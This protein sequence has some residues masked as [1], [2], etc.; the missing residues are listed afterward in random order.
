MPGGTDPIPGFGS[1]A[2]DPGRAK[3]T[4]HNIDDNADNTDTYR[5]FVVPG[6]QI[7]GN[8]SDTSYGS[9]T[10]L[11]G[12]DGL[13]PF[14][15]EVSLQIDKVRVCVIGDTGSLESAFQVGIYAAD[16]DW[17]PTSLVWSTEVAV[18]PPQYFFDEL[19]V[20]FSLSPGRYLEAICIP[21]DLE[22]LLYPMLNWDL[23]SYLTFG[24]GDSLGY[25]NFSGGGLPYLGLSQP[26]T[27]GSGQPSRPFVS[28]DRA[29]TY[30]ALPDPGDPW[31]YAWIA[32]RLLD[33]TTIPW[34]GYP[35]QLG[36]VYP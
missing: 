3:W 36:V 34:I 11:T 17:Q 21:A 24:A 18:S 5:G 1:S 4:G 22:G 33:L 35:L 2:I 29:R 8:I 20:D 12:Y 23:F 10:G 26:S 7:F 9:G 27:G 30:G 14:L 15:T 19:D 6:V 16:L 25:Y 13:A 31:D 32:D 28:I